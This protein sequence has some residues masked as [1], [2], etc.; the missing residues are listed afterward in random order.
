MEEAIIGFSLLE[1]SAPRSCYLRQRWKSVWR[2]SCTM[3][4]PM[5][6]NDRAMATAQA[7]LP[8]MPLCPAQALL[9]S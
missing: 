1:R 4:N 5:I 3:Q 7:T 6:I 9:A 8:Q 2:A